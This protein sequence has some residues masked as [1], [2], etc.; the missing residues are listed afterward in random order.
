MPCA[1]IA[2]AL[3]KITAHPTTIRPMSEDPNLFTEITPWRTEPL[4]AFDDWIHIARIQGLSRQYSGRSIHVYRA[5]WR[6]VCRYMEVHRTNPVDMDAAHI[7][8]FLQML[9]GKKSLRAG[10]SIRRRYVALLARV[11]DEI[12]S[13]GIRHTNPARERSVQPKTAEHKPLPVVLNGE[14]IRTLMTAGQ[15]EYSNEPW[16]EVRDRALVQLILGGGL[17]LTEARRLELS[18]LDLDGVAPEVLIRAWG[19]RPERRAKVETFVLAPMREW[20]GLRERV[21]KAGNMVFPSK[22]NGQAMNASSVYRLV[23]NVLDQAGIQKSHLGPSLLRH[24]F[25][26]R[27]AATGSTAADLKERLGYAEERSGVVYG[28]ITSRVR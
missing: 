4:K 24:T 17:K 7:E 5:M 26:T 22:I 3:C 1:L 11:F 25:A 18:D 2:F 28:K 9:R 27:C 12:V 6:K 15:A 20:L 16:R 8:R 21:I 14:Q 23:A 19:R 13:A 10:E